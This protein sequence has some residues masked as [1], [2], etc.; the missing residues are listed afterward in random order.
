MNEI[1]I[2]PQ[3]GNS[4]FVKKGQFLKVIAI[5]D[6]QVGD[7]VAFNAD[8][9][10]E[11]LSN[12]K[13]FDYEE[14]I[15]L[16]TGNTL[17]SNLSHPMLEIV[18]DTC[19]VHDFLLAPCCSNTM[20]HFYGMEDDGPSC[21]SN[22]STALSKHGVKAW[23]IP[24]AFNIFMNVPVAQNGKIEV[25]PPVA[26]NGDFIVFKSHMD[27]LIGLTA[28]SAADSNNGSFKPIAYNILESV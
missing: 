27:L 25:L 3:T 9:L 19:G 1:I 14:T 17:Y 22:L 26:R 13:T 7:L 5:A 2:P 16:S 20:R 4:F 6:Q 8:D 24:T 12:G 10:T 15:E 18:Q 28:C 21:Q 11:H 23:Q